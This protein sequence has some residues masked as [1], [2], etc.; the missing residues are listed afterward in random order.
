MPLVPAVCTQCGAQIKVDDSKEAGICDFCGTAFITEKAIQTFNITNNIN[1]NTSGT[2]INIYY[3]SSKKN[4]DNNI[5]IER[6][7]PYRITISRKKKFSGCAIVYKFDVEGQIYEVK[8]GGVISFT[9]T[10]KHLN[11][12]IAQEASIGNQQCKPF[13]GYLT[14][15]ADGSDIELCIAVG[16]GFERFTVDIITKSNKSINIR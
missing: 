8:N 2:I 7:A 14:G 6:V 12:K 9:T 10:I 16:N 13:Y 3:D 5:P 4:T 11:I 15:E 1:I